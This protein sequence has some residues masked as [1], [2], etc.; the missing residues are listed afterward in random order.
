MVLAAG[1]ASA[2]AAH[3]DQT[4]FEESEAPATGGANTV[5]FPSKSFAFGAFGTLGE[6]HSS[7]RLGDY[8]LDSSI[9]KG[10]GLSKNLSADND[11]RLGIQVQSNFAPRTSAVLQVV[12]EYSDDNTYQPHVEWANVKYAFTPNF[13]IR[14]GRVALPT[15]L[16]SDSRKVGYSYPWIHPPVELYRQLAITNSDGIDTS[17]RFAIEGASNVVKAIVGRNTLS[18]PTTTQHSRNIVGIFDT[19][20]HG[21]ATLMVGYQTRESSTVNLPEGSAPWIRN[22]DLS[23]AASYDPGDWFATTEWIQR[24]SSTRTTAMY[25]STGRRIHDFTP[26][27]TYCQSSPASPR[28]GFLPTSTNIASANIS[29][30][31]VSLGTRWDFTRRVDFKLQVDLV[32]L[33]SDSNG[34]LANVPDDV[35][36]HGARFHLISATLDFAF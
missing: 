6:S 3:A 1:I 19:L 10:P 25:V 28:S 9:P 8:V 16:Y 27:V 31:T 26:Y 4:N 22:A 36:L 2:T 23:I 11:S 24:D 13:D 7:E 18:R 30:A 20:V 34:Y 32:R 33:G 21:P 35:S 12:T 29:Q 14:A 17:Y 5:E 15:F